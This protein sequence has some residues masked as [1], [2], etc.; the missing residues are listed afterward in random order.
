MNIENIKENE[1]FQEKIDI[2]SLFF[3]KHF[4]ENSKYFETLLKLKDIWDKVYDDNRMKTSFSEAQVLANK[5]VISQLFYQKKDVV[6][7]IAIKNSK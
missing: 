2:L 1:E 4:V 7:P 5:E 3:A 6:T